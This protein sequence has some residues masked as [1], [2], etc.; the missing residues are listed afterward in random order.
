[1]IKESKS[2]LALKIGVFGEL[3]A[4]SLDKKGRV[5]CKCSCGKIPTFPATKLLD[6]IVTCCGHSFGGITKTN[7][8]KTK[9]F[10]KLEVLNGDTGSKDKL[11]C[12]CACG[13][14]LQVR[15]KDLFL[16]SKT[17]CDKCKDNRTKTRKEVDTMIADSLRIDMLTAESV[18]ESRTTREKVF[19]YMRC[20]CGKLK[21][22]E[23]RGLLKLQYGSC[24]CFKPKEVKPSPQTQQALD[25]KEF[26][27]LNVIGWDV[28]RPNYSL[29]ICKCG[30]EKYVRS[31]SLLRG[32]S[33]SCGCRA[34]T[35]CSERF[36]GKFKAD[37]VTRHPLYQIY[38]SM[39]SRCYNK[40]N[41]D[42][43]H[44]GGRGI[45]VCDRWTSPKRD[46]TGFY[47]FLSDMEDTYEKGLEIERL[48]VN[49]NYTPENCKWI[50][51]K[52]Q[53]NN[54]RVNRVLEGFGIKLNVAEWGEFLGFNCKM[55]DD[56]INKGKDKR[57]LEDILKDTFRDRQYTLIYKGVECNATYVWDAE[58]YTLGQRNG[59]LN[60]Y[61]DSLSAFAA[62]GIE[63]EL[64]VGRDKEYMTFEEALK[65]LRD[66]PCRNHFEEHLLF[67]IEN[68]LDKDADNEV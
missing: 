64:V 39:F 63:V 53:V 13:E 14:S 46:I 62:E 3:T 4:K 59:R 33:T 8:I 25:I 17:S 58:G 57:K 40:N 55:L 32:D 2:E 38:K 60:K 30:V 34:R 47:N 27:Y 66:K 26:T 50:C 23:Y 41:T 10:G 48:D 9:N 49:G 36:K 1:M 7:A 29:C 12:L 20:D 61:G 35:L 65:C 28:K 51:R 22:F 31:D 5:K 45:T 15:Y 44:Y 67:K 16:K 37:A 52:S 6:G 21:S 19:I 54:L 11:N 42:F 43:K 56:R 68:Q 18:D 24:G